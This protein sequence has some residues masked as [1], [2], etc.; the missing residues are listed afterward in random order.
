MRNYKLR[1]DDIIMRHIITCLFFNIILFAI[2]YKQYN[3]MI[4]IDDYVVC[5]ILLKC[6]SLVIS[7]LLCC[8][9]YF[10]VV[11][12]IIQLKLFSQNDN[13][14]IMFL[15]YYETIIVTRRHG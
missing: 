14:I 1:R 2:F 3:N 4:S 11:R 9:T 10:G 15:Y 6:N 12:F 5:N 8:N 7:A 13:N